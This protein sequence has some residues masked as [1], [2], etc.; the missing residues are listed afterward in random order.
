MLI[1]TRLLWCSNAPLLLPR[2][3]HPIQLA[4]TRTSCGSAMNFLKTYARFKDVFVKNI[5][6]T[7]THSHIQSGS[8]NSD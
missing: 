3:L 4:F 7:T 6:V 1:I 2:S 8:T 5:I